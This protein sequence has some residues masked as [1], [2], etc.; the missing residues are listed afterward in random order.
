MSN[1]L[2]KLIEV[3]NE[4][5]EKINSE[6]DNRKQEAYYISELVQRNYARL[7]EVSGSDD[8][9]KLYDFTKQALREAKDVCDCYLR[10]SESVR[11]A[12]LLGWV[13]IPACGMVPVAIPACETVPRPFSLTCAGREVIDDDKTSKES[14]HWF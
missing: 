10:D 5:F 12:V 9:R 2:H 11:K 14:L 3:L 1:R 4:E 6:A 13:E 7:V 8:Y